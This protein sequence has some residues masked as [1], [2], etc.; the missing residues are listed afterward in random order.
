VVVPES[1]FAAYAGKPLPVK[2]GIKTGS[3]VALI[4]APDGFADSLDKL[5]SGVVFTTLPE[6]NAV[7]FLWFVRS[8]QQL[9][10]DTEL[11]IRAAKRAPVWIAWPKKG[12]NLECDLTQQTVRQTGLNAGLVDYKICSVDH[13]WSALLF[14][15]RG[16]LDNHSDNGK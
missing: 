11:I 4:G 12:S 2:L 9:S 1:V 6:D 7:L 10:L 13:D 8:Y 5:S 15:W 3:K 16:I 14:T